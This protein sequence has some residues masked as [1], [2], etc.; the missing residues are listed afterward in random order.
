MA[1]ADLSQ[2]ADINLDSDDVVTVETL[3][4]EIA[5]LIDEQTDLNTTTSS[6]MYL[7][8]A[9]QTVTF[10]LILCLGMRRSTVYCLASAGIG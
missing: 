7:V 8:A 2:A 6:A 1:D 5:D 3:N 10:I 9:T 4:N